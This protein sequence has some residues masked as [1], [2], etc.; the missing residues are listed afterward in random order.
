MNWFNIVEALLTVK[1]TCMANIIKNSI[2]IGPKCW[3][4]FLIAAQKLTKL[5]PNERVH[6]SWHTAK[7]SGWFQHWNLIEICADFGNRFWLDPTLES[8]WI[9]HWN[10]VEFKCYIQLEYVWILEII[11]GWIQ[12]WNLVEIRAEFIIQFWLNSCQ[13]L[14]EI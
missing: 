5:L 10:L 9:K 13:N 4:S 8:G 12:H 11:F 1:V 3:L 6:P 7:K 14:G 2:S